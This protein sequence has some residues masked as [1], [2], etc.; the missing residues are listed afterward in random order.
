MIRAWSTQSNEPPVD[1]PAASFDEALGRAYE[2][3][4]DKRWRSVIVSDLQMTVWAQF[5][6]LWSLDPAPAAKVRTDG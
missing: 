4:M 2:M 5:N 6:M 1:T 3:A